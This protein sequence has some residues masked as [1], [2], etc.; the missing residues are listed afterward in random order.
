MAS[1]TTHIRVRKDLLKE[2]RM[3]FPKMT[4]DEI[5]SMSWNTYKGLQ[6][7]GRMIYGR[8]WK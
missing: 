6:K 5:V 4:T 3:E 1:K 8:M 7:A 2:M